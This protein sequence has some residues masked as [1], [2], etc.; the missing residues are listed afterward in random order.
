LLILNSE[1]SISDTLVSCHR[2]NLIPLDVTGGLSPQVVGVEEF[3]RV[4]GVVLPVENVRRKRSKRTKS[5]WAK[6]RRTEE[7]T[8]RLFRISLMRGVIGQGDQISPLFHE[9]AQNFKLINLSILPRWVAGFSGVRVLWLGMALGW[10]PVGGVSR[11][12][13]TASSRGRTGR[14]LFG[15]GDSCS[16][17][18]RPRGGAGMLRTGVNPSLRC[19]TTVCYTGHQAGK[20]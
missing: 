12:V 20:R 1:K 10:R 15:H 11:V 5:P 2:I 14:T 17:Q 9:G 13:K 3:T 18:A 6:R 8:F 4:A 19:H 7:V 16:P